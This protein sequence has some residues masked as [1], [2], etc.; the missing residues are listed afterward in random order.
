MEV[1]QDLLHTDESA[2]LMDLGWIT[3]GGPTAPPPGAVGPF[4][5]W[6]CGVARAC[7][8]PWPSG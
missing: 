5:H 2:D 6:A 3:T 4:R 8:S 1:K 7:R